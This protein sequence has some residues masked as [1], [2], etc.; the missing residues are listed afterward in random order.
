MGVPVVRARADEQVLAGRGGHPLG[1]GTVVGELR[2]AAV[3]PGAVA[4]GGDGRPRAEV[5]IAGVD[6][7]VLGKGWGALPGRVTELAVAA[8]PGV[9]V[10]KREDEVDVVVVVHAVYR[11]KR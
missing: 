11:L 7:D 6:F 10:L 4:V 5:R 8:A 9:G 3:V 1:G 2:R